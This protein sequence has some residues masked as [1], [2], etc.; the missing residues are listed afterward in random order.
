MK[1]SDNIIKKYKMIQKSYKDENFVLE[2]AQLREQC[3]D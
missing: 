2:V 3:R 1:K